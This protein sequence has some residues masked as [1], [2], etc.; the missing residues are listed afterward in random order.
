MVGLA[1]AIATRTALP[2]SEVVVLEARP[3]PQGNPDPLDTRASALNLASRSILEHWGLWSSLAAQSGV[4]EKIHVSNQG[5]FGSSLITPEDIGQAPLGYVIENHTLGRAL[6][7]KSDELGIEL[8]APAEVTSLAT[9]PGG[10]G[11]ELARGGALSADLVI[12]ADGNQSALRSRL[13]VD[14][15]RR[16]NGQSAVVANVS[17]PG[18]QTH[19]AYERFTPEGP[20][21]MLPLPSVQSGHRR[22]NL[23]WSMASAR[24][25]HMLRAEDADFAAAVQHAF[26]WR[27]GPVA[28][29]GKRSGWVLDRNLAREQVRQ[30]FLVAGNAAHGI[31]PVAGQ[32][33]NLSLRDAATLQRVLIEAVK[34]QRSVGD[35]NT[36]QRYVALVRDDQAQTVAATDLLATLF[37]R[38]GVMLDLPRD[39]ALAALDLVAPV[40]RRIAR[41]GTGLD[42]P[43]VWSQ[44]GLSA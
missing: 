40:R 3:I 17:F 42:I 19:L 8:I 22:F 32:G 27:L 13:G 39:A 14:V 35:L 25:E 34:D 26:G 43:P 2:Q 29:V 38:R 33:L 18:D 28:A 9:Q 5:R 15:D 4:I 23:V 6:K 30:G 1:F 20:L 37:N 10:T 7:A 41:R 12:V 36:L 11:I 21:A 44:D 16:A 24:A 31:H